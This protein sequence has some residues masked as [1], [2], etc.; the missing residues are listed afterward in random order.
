[1][2]SKVYFL[3]K[4]IFQLWEEKYAHTRL[5]ARAHTHTHAHASTEKF[6]NIQHYCYYAI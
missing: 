2:N 6:Q 4:G 5:H 1:M 3:K